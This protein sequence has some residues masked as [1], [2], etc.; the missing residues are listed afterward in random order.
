[1]ASLLYYE[2]GNLRRF[3]FTSN[4]DEVKQLVYKSYYINQS[5]IAY[6]EDFKKQLA[7]V[8]NCGI[9]NKEIQILNYNAK[10]LTKIFNK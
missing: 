9:D 8:L 10:S 2:N 5:Q 3:F 6:N 7:E 1:K 4:T